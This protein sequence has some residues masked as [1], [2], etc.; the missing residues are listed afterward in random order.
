MKAYDID[1]TSTIKKEFTSFNATLNK[2]Q[3]G[4]EKVDKAKTAVNMMT[5]KYKDLPDW[6]KERYYKESGY[7]KDQIEYGAMTSHNEVS[8]MDNYW[9]QKAQ[10]SSHEDLIQELANG[11][12]KS[13]TGQMFAKNGVINKLRAEGY[14]TKQEARA[15]NATQFDTDGNKI[16]K[17]T[18]GGSGRSSSGRGRGRRGGSSSG[19][20]SASPLSSAVTKS[21]GLTSSAPKANESSAKN[22][23]INQIGQNLISKANTQK[24][25]TNTLK[26]W[27]GASTSKNTRIRIKKA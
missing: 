21:M 26:K 1:K 22:T 6:V 9:R 27:N 4:T 20:G 7:T 5:G 18:S 17:D 16:T 25:I 23:S 2:L 13:I 8:L 15:L 14:I 11:R 24:Q 19:R 3:N 10:E 12:R